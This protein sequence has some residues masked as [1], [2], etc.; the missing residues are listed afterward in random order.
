M[1][2]SAALP[3]SSAAATAAGFGELRHTAA[4]G[5]TN[6]DLVTQARLGDRSQVV[7]VA[8]HQHAGRGRVGR[9][10]VDASG[11]PQG[12]EASL[13]VSFRLKAPLPD[14]HGCVAAVSAAALAAAS[15]AVEGCGSGAAALRSKWPNDLL[16]CSPDVD[17]KLAGVLSETVAGDP[18]VVVV[19][20]GMNLAAAPDQPGAAALAQ[21][22]TVWGRDRLLARLLAELPSYLADPT[23][24]CSDLRAM[25]ATL[26]SL[27][28]VQLA[29]GVTVEG[30]AVDIDASGRLVLEAPGAGLTGTAP[31][32]ILIDTGDVIHLRDAGSAA[33]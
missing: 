21:L 7:L 20:L 26:G 3:L 29:G 9:R 13:L 16:I 32:T 1:M 30:V 11:G 17:G 15:A 14:A 33:N 10:W 27:V 4:T 24:A 25:S 22:G 2:P 8:D 23:A 19:G 31:Q 18:P 28:R 5:S 6:D 12:S